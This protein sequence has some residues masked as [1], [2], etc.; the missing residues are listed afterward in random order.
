M[1]PRKRIIPVFVPHLG[2]P[3]DCVF[4]NQRTISGSLRPAGPQDVVRALEEARRM[5]ESA[6]LAFYGG[7]F[8]N[9]P[10]EQQRALLEAAQ[11]YRAEGFLRS[12]RVSTRP[13]AVT[14][15]GLAMLMAY[16]VETVELGAQSMED[17]VLRLSGRGHTAE[18]TVRASTLVKEAGLRLILQMMTGLPGASPESD[19]R[20]AQAIAALGPDGV[21]I[22]PTVILR[23]TAL[24]SLW[25]EGKYR[26]HNISDAVETCAPIAARFLGEGIPILRLGLN[27]TEALSGGEAVG[28]AYHPALGELVYSKLYLDLA[29]EKLR[30]I[31]RLPRKVELLVSENCVSKMTGRKQA[32]LL[33]LRWEFGLEEVSVSGGAFLPETVEIRKI[34]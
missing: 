9:L 1:T 31:P 27:P 29:R 3:N 17:R 13:D 33:A 7:S 30:R 22:Y 12:L 19:L 10:E 28:G 2:C 32:N 34:L 18:D 4:C 24:E 6:E 14:A 20:T 21:R 11:P 8:T 26:A 16:G 23:G 25:R 15:P 5:T